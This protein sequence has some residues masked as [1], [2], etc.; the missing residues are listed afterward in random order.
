MFIQKIKY[1]WVVNLILFGAVV[2][3]GIEQ[4]GRGAEISQLENK[5][6]SA[7]TTKRDLAEGVFNG[8]S[9]TKI[10]EN[11][12]ELGFNKPQSVYYF[13]TDDLFARLPVR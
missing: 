13:K 10:A 1:I 3:L 7:I 12:Q 11:S 8:S 2:F 9:D 6:E 5:I 4:A